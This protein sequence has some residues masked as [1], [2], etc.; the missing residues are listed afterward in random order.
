MSRPGLTGRALVASNVALWPL[1]LSN[2]RR[3]RAR[4]AICNGIPAV[5]MIRCLVLG[6]ALALRVD[7]TCS[8]GLTSN[9]ESIS[10]TA[11]AL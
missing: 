10:G 4:L 9:R 2:G 1:A 5:C 3:L 7:I 6:A 8:S 11:G